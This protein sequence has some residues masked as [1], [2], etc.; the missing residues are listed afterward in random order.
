MSFWSWIY[1]VAFPA[2]GAKVTEAT[3][4]AQEYAT[5]AVVDWWYGNDTSTAG[6]EDVN[7]STEVDGDGK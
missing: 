3:D 2:F 7:V 6:V 4:D 1:A 5:D